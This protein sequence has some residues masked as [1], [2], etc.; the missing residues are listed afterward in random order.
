MSDSR[1]FYVVRP[2]VRTLDAVG[3]AYSVRPA[4]LRSRLGNYFSN[5]LKGLWLPGR[6]P[7]WRSGKLVPTTAR[8]RL[9]VTQDDQGSRRIPY[10]SFSTP[11]S[12]RRCSTRCQV[13]RRRRRRRPTVMGSAEGRTPS[14]SRR[15]AQPGREWEGKTVSQGMPGD[16]YGAS[17]GLPGVVAHPVGILRL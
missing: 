16:A 10:C 12:A 13:T 8:L 5:T 14:R 4:S 2:P 17:S 11:I 3:A 1:V 7:C 15:F 6:P 9:T